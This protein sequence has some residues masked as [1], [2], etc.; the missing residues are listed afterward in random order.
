MTAKEESK[1]N[2]DTAEVNKHWFPMTFLMAVIAIVLICFRE[3]TEIAVY[4]TLYNFN[5]LNSNISLLHANSIKMFN[6]EID[7]ATNPNVYY[8]FDNLNATLFNNLNDS[9]NSNQKLTWSTYKPKYY[10]QISDYPSSGVEIGTLWH[11][12]SVKFAVRNGRQFLKQFLKN[13]RYKVLPKSDKITYDYELYDPIIGYGKQIIK[14][15][16]NSVILHYEFVTEGSEIAYKVNG[17]PLNANKGETI[18]MITFMNQKYKHEDNTL[19]LSDT[20]EN[21]NFNSKVFKGHNSK[22][23]NYTITVTSLLGKPYASENPNSFPNTN[24]SINNHLSIKLTDTDSYKIFE[25]FEFIMK[26][27]ASFFLNIPGANIQDLDMS[28]LQ[29]LL[30]VDNHPEFNR[31]EEESLNTGNLHFLQSS[32]SLDEPF[33]YIVILNGKDN[34]ISNENIDKLIIEKR[35]QTAN[36]YQS[37]FSYD[38]L[39]DEKYHKFSQVTFANLFSSLQFS[40]GLLNYKQSENSNFDSVDLGPY[41]LMHLSP[42]RNYFPRGFYWD[43]GFHLATL[44]LYSSEL[45]L[46]IIYEWFSVMMDKETGYIPRELFLGEDTKDGISSKWVTQYGDVGNPDVLVWTFVDIL[47]TAIQH[48]DL[49]GLSLIKELLVDGGL[50]E[51]FK[52]RFAWVIDIHSLNSDKEDL[53]FKK[54]FLK[55]KLYDSIE[56]DSVY[57]WK[58]QTN[59]HCFSSG[60]DDYPRGMTHNKDEINLYEPA[61]EIH[62]DLMSWVTLFSKNLFIIARFLKIE[63]DMRYYKT[64]LKQNF[65]NLEIL[66][67]DTEK[68]MYCDVALKSHNK[69]ME[70]VCHEGYVSLFPFMLQLV[71]KEDTEKLMHFIEMLG[72]EQGLFSP[73]GIRSLSKK[74]QY[75][76]T[77]EDYWRSKVWINMNYMILNSLHYYFKEQMH[78]NS[79]LFLEA[80]S[81]YEKLRTNIVENMYENWKSNDLGIVYENYNDED[82]VGKGVEGFTGWSSL[83]INILYQLP[84]NL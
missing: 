21:G 5:I 45:S 49:D 40:E 61:C 41:E 75:Y 22:L 63:E 64:V 43:E 8:S 83:I 52:K 25:V 84:E 55:Q 80:S 1:D 59:D 78:F 19:Y 13:L 27:I 10:F 73:F 67:Y 39:S 34:I 30:D 37:K 6:E 3:Q 68:N 33:E 57:Q 7:V 23:D 69:E 65:K 24:N 48:N 54:S 4:E 47:E 79:A 31:E 9:S 42:S 38:S 35:A 20:F 28:N 11:K 12:S 50:Y 14:D 77:D 70:H 81:V 82:G 16:Q 2:A 44:K 32:Y 60:L 51:W 58:D 15:F 72:N 62:V 66:N 74:D 71:P 17:T 36:K 76:K 53:C 46:K 29:Q 56:K 26:R 18:S